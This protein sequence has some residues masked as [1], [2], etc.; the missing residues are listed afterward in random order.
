MQQPLG[1]IV[2]HRREFVPERTDA[3]AEMRRRAHKCVE[4]IDRWLVERGTPYILGEEFSAADI[5][6]GYSMLLIDGQ[7]PLPDGA[8]PAAQEYWKRLQGRPA[9]QA[10]VAD[11]AP[12]PPPSSKL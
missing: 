4:A 12:P 1:E 9:W 10:S 5:M 3:I 11:M 8:Y 2:N 6:L 7:A